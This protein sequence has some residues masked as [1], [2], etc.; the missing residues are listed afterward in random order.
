VLTL[1]PVVLAS[2][3]VKTEKAHPVEAYL[4]GVF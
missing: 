1:S 4:G 2:S 3:S